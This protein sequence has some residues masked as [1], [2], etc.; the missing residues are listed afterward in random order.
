MLDIK[1]ESVENKKNECETR[2]PERKTAQSAGYDFFL[3]YDVEIMPGES[4]DIIFT[5]VKVRLPGNFFLSIHIRSSLGFKHGL[6]LANVTGII[7]ADYY[8]N[9][10]N[11]GNIGI[12]IHNDGKDPVKLQAGD[13]F[14]QGIISRY[15]TAIDDENTEDRVG[16]FGST[17]K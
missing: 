5:D 11:E 10:D 1:F 4:S 13:R 12:K 9:H 2:L 15:Y 6:R 16:G 17:G 7:D 3:P 14:A 8:N